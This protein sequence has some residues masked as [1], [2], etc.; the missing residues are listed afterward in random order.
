MSDLVIYC[1]FSYY[2]DFNTLWLF[3]REHCPTLF[4]YITQQRIKHVCCTE[5]KVFIRLLANKGRCVQ[6][7]LITSNT[8]PNFVQ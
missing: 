6:G 4:I 7:G 2:R 3:T 1:W 5:I 8:L